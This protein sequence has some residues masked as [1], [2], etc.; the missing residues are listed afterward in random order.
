MNPELQAN[1]E[2]SNHRVV[3][4]DGGTA[5]GKGRLVDELSQLMRLK[6]IP[7]VHLSTGSLYRAVALAVMDAMR[8]HVKGKRGKTVAEVNGE[9]LELARELDPDKFVE[10]ARPRQIEMHGGAVWMDGAPVMVDERLKAPSV[11]TGASVVARH[12]PVRD[13]VNEITRR[14][15]NEFDGYL[16]IDGRDIGT[17]VVPDAPLKLLLVVSPEIAAERSREHSKAEIIAR[18]HADRNREHGSLPHPDTV[19]EDVVVL[20]TDDHTPETLRDQVYALMRKTFPDLPK[21]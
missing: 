15:V 5:T 10:L 3:A 19:P 16:L 2:L 11:G 9:A 1:V 14:Q 6:G 4:V 12:L 8:G 20:A 21:I 17:V 18:D 13:F 7:V